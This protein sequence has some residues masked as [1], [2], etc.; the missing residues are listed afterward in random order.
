MTQYR[1]LTTFPN[2]DDNTIWTS[3]HDWYWPDPTKAHVWNGESFIKSDDTGIADLP[4]MLHWNKEY[5]E[6]QPDLFELVV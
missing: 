5:V 6:N 4:D 1:Q 2:L 3:D